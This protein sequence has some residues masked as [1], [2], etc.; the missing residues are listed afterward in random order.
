V[1]GASGLVWTPGGRLRV[2]FDFTI[3]HGKNVA[4]N[5]IGDPERIGA[6]RFGDPRVTAARICEGPGHNRTPV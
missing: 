5:L 3:A 6:I 1:N 2:V 4:V